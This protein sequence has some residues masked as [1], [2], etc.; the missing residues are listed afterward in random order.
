MHGLA[1][2]GLDSLV[3]PG[4][5][6]GNVASIDSSRKPADSGQA[7]AL[8]ADGPECREVKLGKFY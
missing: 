1:A 5:G 6:P 8:V 2:D 7:Q 4:A 3:E